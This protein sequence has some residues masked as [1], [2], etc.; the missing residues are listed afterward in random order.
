MMKSD[1]NYL[2]DNAIWWGV[3]ENS[4]KNQLLQSSSLPVQAALS[5]AL[6]VTTSAGFIHPLDLVKT[7]YQVATSATVAG[8]ATG[9]ENEVL[10]NT[11]KRV[12]RG[13]DREGI[14]Q[15]IRNVRAEGGW[16][17]FYR[18]FFPRLG[19]SIPSALIMMTCLEY[20][21]P[22]DSTT[23]DSEVEEVIV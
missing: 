3:Y 2:T 19:C 13:S 21:K 15:I 5:S 4:K 9:S 20:L 12:S 22:D 23:R 1:I 6:A 16:I 14:K 8:L 11:D 7:R 18:G 10:G 17:S